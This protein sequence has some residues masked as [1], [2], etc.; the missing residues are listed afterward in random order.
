MACGVKRAGAGMVP[1]AGLCVGIIAQVVRQL[2]T[3]VFNI[4]WGILSRTIARKLFVGFLPIG[5][6]YIQIA[7]KYSKA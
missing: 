2:G 3:L 4:L 6:Q 5:D 7:Y 1:H